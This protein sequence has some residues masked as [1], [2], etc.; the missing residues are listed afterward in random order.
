[1]SGTAVATRGDNR[2]GQQL[3]ES[4]RDKHAQ[5]D[6]T[7]QRDTGTQ[8]S[9]S[10]AIDHSARASVPLQRCNNTMDRFLRRTG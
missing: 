9:E 7:A 2:C 5:R 1:M 10:T 8:H 4:G 3:R 6:C